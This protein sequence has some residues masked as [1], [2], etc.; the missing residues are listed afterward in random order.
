[1]FGQTFF[2]TDSPVD[3]LPSFPMTTNVQTPEKTKHIIRLHTDFGRFGRKAT[4]RP[5]LNLVLQTGYRPSTGFD[6]WKIL[7]L[8]I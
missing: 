7:L 5:C 3:M 6:L 1:M 2:A 4:M 8:F